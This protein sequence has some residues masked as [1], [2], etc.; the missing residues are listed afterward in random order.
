MT[1]ETGKHNGPERRIASSLRVPR[2]RAMTLSV[3]K[4]RLASTASRKMKIPLV[5][6]ARRDEVGKDD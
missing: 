2:K 5:D 4:K 1:R 6:Y 3:A